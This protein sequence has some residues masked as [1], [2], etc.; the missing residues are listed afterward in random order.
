MGH[1]ARL[2]PTADKLRRI[3]VAAQVLHVVAIWRRVCGEPSIAFAQAQFLADD[4]IDRVVDAI[5]AGDAAAG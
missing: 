1:F 5:S 4:D 3:V 2:N